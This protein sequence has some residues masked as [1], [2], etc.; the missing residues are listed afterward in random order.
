MTSSK[1]VLSPLV[2]C[3]MR[4]T[5]GYLVCN[6]LLHPNRQEL[7]SLY[8]SMKFGEGNIVPAPDS[9]VLAAYRSDGQGVSIEEF[10]AES[11]VSV[12]GIHGQTTSQC[13]TETVCEERVLELP[14]ESKQLDEQYQLFT[15]KRADKRPRDDDPVVVVAPALDVPVSMMDT[16]AL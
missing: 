2:F 14:L 6:S 5:K 15:S 4:C 13:I 8:V 3:S 10:R 1:T 11:G 12:L 16:M 9:S 7:F